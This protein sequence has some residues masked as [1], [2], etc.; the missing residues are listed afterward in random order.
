MKL[1]LLALTA[2]LAAGPLAAPP[3]F[4]AD[5]SAPLASD[6]AYAKSVQDWRARVEQSL[7]KDNGWLTLAGRYVLKPGENT[8]GTGAP[9]TSSFRRD[10]GPPA[11]DRSSS[12]PAAS[13]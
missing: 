9:T 4:A 6:P 5:D 11:W 13:R 1:A 12:S 8:F 2:T 7:R 3:L 10:S